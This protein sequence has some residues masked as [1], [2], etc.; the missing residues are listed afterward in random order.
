MVVSAVILSFLTAGVIFGHAA[1][2]TC[3]ESSGAYQDLCNG[4]DSCPERELKLV[5]LF[6]IAASVTNI[7]ALIFGTILDYFGPKKSGI[8]GSILFLGGC[9]FMSFPTNSNFVNFLVICD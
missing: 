5:L 4:K 8:L 9:L 2:R 1:L 6:T 3:L 7:S